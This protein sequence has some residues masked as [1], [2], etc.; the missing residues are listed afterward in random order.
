MPAKQ[1]PLLNGSTSH[2]S[3]QYGACEPDDATRI[4]RT[5]D[6]HRIGFTINRLANK[7]CMN[8][9][10]GIMCLFYVAINIITL[11][12]NTF[13]GARRDRHCYTFHLLEFWATFFFSIVSL[14]SFIFSRKR[15]N[16]IHTNATLLKILLFANVVFSAVPALFVTVDLHY[17]DIYAHEVEYTVSILQAILDIIVFKLITKDSGGYLAPFIFLFM[18]VL[19]LVT[20]NFFENGEQLSHYFEFTFEICTATIMFCFCVDNKVFLDGTLCHLFH[21]GGH[22]KE[23]CDLVL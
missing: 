21:N 8:F 6:F 13:T 9:A 19:Q 12:M 16:T 7:S 18:A 22:C 14:S 23:Y 15:L 10:L 17:F 2:L 4:S 20:Y 11:C 1:K 3:S 5:N